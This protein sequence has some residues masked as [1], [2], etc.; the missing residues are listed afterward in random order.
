MSDEALLIEKT[1]LSV[2]GITKQRVVVENRDFVSMDLGLSAM[3]A[4]VLL[5]HVDEA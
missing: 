3:T 2:R 1:L 5:E 4:T